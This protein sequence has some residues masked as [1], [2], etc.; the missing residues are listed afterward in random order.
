M[1]NQHESDDADASSIMEEAIKAELLLPSVTVANPLVNQNDDATPREGQD[2]VHTTTDEKA[3]GSDLI[4]RSDEDESSSKSESESR[5]EAS[6]SS[7]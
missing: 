1:L 4:S 5:M 7:E 6:S 2:S 3:S